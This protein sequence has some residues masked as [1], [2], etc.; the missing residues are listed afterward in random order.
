MAKTKGCLFFFFK[1][2]KLSA[3]ACESARDHRAATRGKGKGTPSPS[4][5]NTFGAAQTNGATPASHVTLDK[6]GSRA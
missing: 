2:L 3:N 5:A 6:R 1:T 4:R